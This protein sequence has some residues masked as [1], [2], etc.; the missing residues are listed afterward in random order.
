M[1]RHEIRIEGG[2]PYPIPSHNFFFLFSIILI[3]FQKFFIFHLS[4]SLS[5]FFLLIS[6]LKMSGGKR[7]GKEKVLNNASFL[8]ILFFHLV[9]FIIFFFFYSSVFFYF[10]FCYFFFFPTRC[11]FSP[12]RMQIGFT[13]KGLR[14]G[15]PSN[16]ESNYIIPQCAVCVSNGEPHQTK[17]TPIIYQRA[18][19][20][21]KL[22][23]E[24]R[25]EEEKSSTKKKEKKNGRFC[26]Y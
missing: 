11:F 21:K 24:N 22:N 18:S 1:N 16:L 3:F 2:G 17:Q 25:N 13:K 19:Q 9:L 14:G 20:K 6:F 4:L 26:Q 8:P 23:K 7:E 15:R 10:L 12:E 5:P